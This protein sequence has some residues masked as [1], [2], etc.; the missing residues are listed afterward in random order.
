M[1][2][3]TRR[4]SRLGAFLLAVCT[5]MLGALLVPRAVHAVPKSFI[6]RKFFEVASGSSVSVTFR[7]ANTAGNLIVASGYVSRVITAPDADIVEDAVASS[8][9]SYGATASLSGGTWLL[10]VAAFAAP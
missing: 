4:R 10:Q 9:G 8:A 1:G 5:T 3:T 6:Q 2:D 7:K